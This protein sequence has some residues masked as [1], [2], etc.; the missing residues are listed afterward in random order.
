M[1]T[2][3][4]KP[5]TNKKLDK[6]F[7]RL[8]FEQ[9]NGTDKLAKNYTK[10]FY[11]FSVALTI[12]FT[13]NGIPELCSSIGSRDCWPKNV[14][15]ILNRV[16]KPNNRTQSRTVISEGMGQTTISQINWLTENTDCE[17]FFIS[18]ETSNWMYW[19]S[20]NFKKQFNLDFKIAENKYLT[21]PNQCDNSCWQHIIYNGNDELLNSWK[22]K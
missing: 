14:Y 2:V 22:S 1:K 11:N 17:L 12:S 18:R 19:V 13:D 10:D 9:E 8:R 6:L 7:E 16:W 4:W 3:T 15:R 20:E 21:C 5:G